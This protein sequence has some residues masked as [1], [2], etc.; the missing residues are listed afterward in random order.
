M[1]QISRKGSETWLDAIMRMAAPH[2]VEEEVRET[3]IQ[4]ISRGSSESKAA[5][6]A[7]V[8][9]DICSFVDDSKW[10]DSL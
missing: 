7:A 10:D 1:L 8:E 5:F 6:F 3:Y 4:E 9:W 2:G